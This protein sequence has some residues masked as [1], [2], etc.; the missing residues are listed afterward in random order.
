MQIQL[1]KYKYTNKT[2]N[3]WWQDDAL[4]LAICMALHL[5]Q[6]EQC[7]SKN[8]RIVCRAGSN[9]KWAGQTQR[10]EDFICMLHRPGNNLCVHELV[11]RE[12]FA[13]LILMLCLAELML[14]L[15]KEKLMLIMCE[16]EL[17]LML[18][19]VE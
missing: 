18:C 11:C 8:N 19:D 6:Q 15:S 17:M 7:T 9:L 12:F 10:S 13:A 4:P 2:H 5:E 1:H 14:M 3:N 16:T